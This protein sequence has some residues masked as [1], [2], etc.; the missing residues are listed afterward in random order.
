MFR[1][2]LVSLIVAVTAQAQVQDT[3]NKKT[4]LFV[5]K[6]ALLLGAFLIGTAAVAPLDM[7]IASRLQYQGT[8]ENQ[9]LGRAATGFRLLGDPG[10]VVVGTAVYLVGRVDGNRRIESV[11]LHSVESILLADVLG[12]GIKM[13]A[14]RQRPFYDIR[15]PYNFQLWRGFSSDQFRS[16]PRLRANRNSGRR[17]RPFTWGPCSMEARHWWGYRAST[18]TS[19]GPAMWWLVQHSVRSLDSKW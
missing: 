11:G 10:S 18:T 1:A 5:G 17:T 12:G 9:L 14:G 8:Q 19:T 13:L 4:P 3:I 2:A 16:F 15:N 7:K 6:D